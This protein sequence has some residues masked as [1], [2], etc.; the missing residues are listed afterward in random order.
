VPEPQMPP[1]SGLEHL[2]AAP[3]APG[4]RVRIGLRAGLTLATVMARKGRAADLARRVRDRIAIEL[5][6]R[7]RRVEAGAVAFAWAGPGRWL[8]TAPEEAEFVARLQAELSD[9]CAVSPQSDGRTVIAISGPAAR[10][11]LAK[12]LPIDLHA[13]AFA[14]GDTALTAAGQIGLQI[15]QR[16]APADHGPAYELVVFRSYAAAM[17]QRLTDAAAEFNVESN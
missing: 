17:W 3:G 13:R 10:A 5:P 1:R 14:P 6:T 16:D 2:V 12:L 9:L 11:T 15:W 7:P 4:G 8:A